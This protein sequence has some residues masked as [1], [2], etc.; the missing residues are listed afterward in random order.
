MLKRAAKAAYKAAPFKPQLLKL[1]RDTV[2][3]PPNVYQHL[4]FDGVFSVD[5]GNG[6]SFKMNHRGRAVENRLFWGGL[7]GYEHTSLE[8]WRR[9]VDDAEAVADIGA[10]TGLYSLYTKALK[11]TVPVAAFEPVARIHRALVENV[12]LNGFDIATEAMA[13]SD[14]SG[15]A[16]LHERAA[17]EFPNNAT[18]DAGGAERPDATSVQIETITLD[19]YL[20]RTGMP[21]PDLMKVDV[22][23][24]EAAVL[25]GMSGVFQVKRPSFV[26]EIINNEVAEGV[27]QVLEGL[28]YVY[29]RVDEGLG[30]VPVERMSRDK[31]RS[32]NFVICTPQKAERLQDLVYAG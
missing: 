13:L 8:V 25:K 6:R 21:V 17:V 19:D 12:R 31:P 30:L 29:L 10:Y 18:L 14:T 9:F 23:K 26:I 5:A 15:W 27:M 1:L 20:A 2:P 16:T 22:E 7:K 32:E 3:V 4:H 28:G 24:H 11:P